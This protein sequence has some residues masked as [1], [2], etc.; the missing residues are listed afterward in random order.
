MVMQSHNTLYFIVSHE[1]VHLWKTD[2]Q[3]TFTKAALFWIRFLGFLL[4]IV[5]SSPWPMMFLHTFKVASQNKVIENSEQSI[6]IRVV[7]RI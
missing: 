1:Y 6:I 4:E 3:T 7:R 5:S 2:S